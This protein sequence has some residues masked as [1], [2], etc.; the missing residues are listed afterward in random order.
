MFTKIRRAIVEAPALMSPDFSK[1]FI[2]YTFATDFSYVAV[3]TQNDHEVTEIP[4]SFMSS[5]FKGVELNYSQVDKQAYMVYKSVK[6]YRPY[7]LKSRTKVIV[8]YVAI[9]NVLVQKELREKRVHW[10]TTL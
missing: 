3:L 10:M 8:P 5:K 7:L 1:D 6:H 2:L 9:R 4:I